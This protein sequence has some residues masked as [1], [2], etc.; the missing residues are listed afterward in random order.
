MPDPD[1]PASFLDG[2]TPIAR[3]VRIEVDGERLR[4]LEGDEEVISWPLAAIEVH[5]VGGGMLR[6]SS[7]GDRRLDVHDPDAI[8]ALTAGLPPPTL[9]GTEGRKRL[10]P[11]IV[12]PALTVAAV[13][14]AWPWIADGVAWVTPPG[15]EARIGR[16]VDDRVFAGRRRCDQPDGLAALAALTDRLSQHSSGGQAVEVSVRDIGEVNA[17][18]LP[19]ATIILSRALLAQAAS[20]EE[21]AGVIAHEMGHVAARHGLRGAY[22]AAGLALIVQLFTGSGMAGDAGVSLATLHHSR[23]VER[24]ADA[25]G[26]AILEAAGIGSAGL[27]TFLERMERREAGTSGML[28]YLSTHPPSG[29]RRSAIP[30]RSAPPPLN[31]TE[32]EALRRICG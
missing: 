9:L 7:D 20:A 28:S 11:R 5:R 13:I 30:P 14:V 4:A 26:V 29:E 8:A 6:L 1:W 15:A 22:R 24:E 10:L 25:R 3:P 27:S 16:Y 21:L 32:W 31:S 2:N 19:G 12:I 17:Y 18:A 23:G